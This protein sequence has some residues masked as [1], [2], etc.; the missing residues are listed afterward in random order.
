MGEVERGAAGRA[1]PFSD[2][3]LEAPYPFH[4][5]L[6]E[7]ALPPPAERHGLPNPGKSS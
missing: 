3:F 6:S 1:H 4:E 5:A 7:A 2:A